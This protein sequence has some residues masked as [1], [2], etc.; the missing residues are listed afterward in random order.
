MVGVGRALR[1]RARARAVQV[2]GRRGRPVVHVVATPAARAAE[3][4]H[5]A[6]AP[7]VVRPP[8]VMLEPR[9]DDAP[10]KRPPVEPH[11]APPLRGRRPPTPCETTASLARARTADV[12]PQPPGERVI[13]RRPLTAAA[14]V[15][16]PVIAG[17]VRP[18]FRVPPL[19]VGVGGAPAQV[20]RKAAVPMG[21]PRAAARPVAGV[22]VAQRVPC[23]VLLTAH[24]AEARPGGRVVAATP[25]VDPEPRPEA[26]T[27][28]AAVAP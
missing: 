3:A 6:A 19:V 1:V 16:R 28:A 9:V 5:G 26:P 20:L 17:R 25:V 4:F 23:V 13:P 24:P 7:R 2:K 10:A 11:G 12:A 8:R 18:P 27:G 22:H 21:G 14:R 15:A